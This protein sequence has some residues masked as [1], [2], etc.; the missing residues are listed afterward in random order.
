MEDYSIHTFHFH[1]AQWLSLTVVPIIYRP[2]F[3]HTQHISCSS[4]SWHY[5]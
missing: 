2:I 3:E 5:W 1:V 4:W